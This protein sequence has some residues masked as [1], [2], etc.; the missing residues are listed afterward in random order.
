MARRSQT[1]WRE[2]FREQEASGLNV[3]AFCR[4]QQVCPKYFSR[5]PAEAQC[6]QCGG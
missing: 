3:A 6:A 5:Y 1:Q 2:L 4:E